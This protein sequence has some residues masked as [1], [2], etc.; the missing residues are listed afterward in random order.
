LYSQDTA[1]DKNND[2]P[3]NQNS[4]SQ[5]PAQNATQ[6]MPS[7]NTDRETA[8]KEDSNPSPAMISAVATVTYAVFTFV[9]CI[10]VAAQVQ[11]YWARERAWIVGSPAQPPGQIVL[12]DKGVTRFFFHI[13]NVGHSPARI[14]HADHRFLV[15]K[16]QDVLPAVPPYITDPK[17]E[18]TFFV[19]APQTSKPIYVDVPQSDINEI[20]KGEK[21]LW[22][23]GRVKYRD[24]FGRKRESRFCFRYYPGVYTV[25]DPDVGF[26]PTGPAEYN[27]LA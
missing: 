25:L 2:T 24:I 8:Y 21:T 4:P 19:I 9:L 13:A 14:L 23:F 20:E 15:V 18:H 1:K 10:F 12:A 3:Q 6:H 7:K 16:R 22:V 27:K 17:G 11:A 5:T 26:I